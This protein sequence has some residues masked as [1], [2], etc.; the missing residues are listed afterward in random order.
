MLR[1]IGAACTHAN[2]AIPRAIG[3]RISHRLRPIM[4]PSSNWSLLCAQGIR[5]P[6]R[7]LRRHFRTGKGIMM[8]ARTRFK[9]LSWWKICLIPYA[10][11]ALI[12]TTTGAHFCPSL[13]RPLTATHSNLWLDLST[14]RG[15]TNIPLTHS[16]V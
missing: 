11:L 8:Q 3:A 5:S 1:H 16:H 6:S 12:P 2:R 10:F 9:K 14:P 7:A 15:C 13:I 4:R